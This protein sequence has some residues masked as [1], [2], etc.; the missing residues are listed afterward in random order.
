MAPA[1]Y[2][3]C[4][5]HTPS[6]VILFLIPFHSPSSLEIIPVL[7]SEVNFPSLQRNPVLWLT[8]LWKVIPRA[9]KQQVPGGHCYFLLALFSVEQPMCWFH[10]MICWAIGGE[11]RNNKSRLIGLV[12][13]LPHKLGARL[14]AYSSHTHTHLLARWH[15]NKHILY[16]NTINE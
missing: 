2:F 9:H 15:S 12:W 3:L 1:Y 4:S 11:H 5:S 16:V 7:I 8:T 13:F 6:I 10:C 14:T